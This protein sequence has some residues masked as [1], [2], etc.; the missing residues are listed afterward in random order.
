MLKLGETGSL[1]FLRETPAVNYV[2]DITPDFEE[3]QYRQE[4]RSQTA[5]RIQAESRRY[6]ALLSTM[7]KTP[8]APQDHVE[9]LATELDAYHECKDFTGATSMADLVV[10]HLQRLLAGEI[11]D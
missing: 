5:R 7:R 6:T 11:R 10:R 2:V 8:I 4:E 3:V 9:Q 1:A